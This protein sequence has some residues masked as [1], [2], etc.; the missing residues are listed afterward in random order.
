MNAQLRTIYP[1]T[2]YSVSAADRLT[3]AVVEAAAVWHEA[4]RSLTD[5]E[6]AIANALDAKDTATAAQLEYA[7]IGAVTQREHAFQYVYLLVCGHR[8]AD[9]WEGLASNGM[10]YRI[11][12]SGPAIAQISIIPQN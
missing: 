12:W 9:Y 1:Y 4:G 11:V 8:S 7:R 6:T 3:R 10:R 5:C 2:A